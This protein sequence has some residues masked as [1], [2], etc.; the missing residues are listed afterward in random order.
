MAYDPS[1]KAVHFGDTT[2]PRDGPQRLDMPLGVESLVLKVIGG[3]GT[4]VGYDFEIR[5][6]PLKQRPPLHLEPARFPGKDAPASVKVLEP[7]ITTGRVQLQIGNDCQKDIEKVSLKLTYRDAAD[8]VLR[9]VERTAPESVAGNASPRLLVAA[10][11]NAPLV[12]IFPPAPAGAVRLEAR[13]TGVEF[14]DA[15]AWPPQ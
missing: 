7:G 3:K 4:K 9:E 12:L 14:I 2:L 15:T 6:I 11:S 5:D 13:V 10:G 1:G 8:K